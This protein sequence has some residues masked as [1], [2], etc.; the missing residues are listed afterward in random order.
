LLI[1][2]SDRQSPVRH[3]GADIKQCCNNTAVYSKLHHESDVDGE[4]WSIILD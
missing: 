1:S 4:R 2:R 3:R